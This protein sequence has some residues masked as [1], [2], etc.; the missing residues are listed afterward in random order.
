MP[1]YRCAVAEGATSLDQRAQIAKAITN[2]HCEITG[3]PP[4]FVHAFFNEVAAADLP[5]DKQALVFGSIR[6][7][8]TAEQQAQLVS[9][10]ARKIGA[11]LGCTAEGVLVATV[12]VPARWIME[13]GAI[14]PEP[15]EEAAWLA[16]HGS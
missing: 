7:G 8:R 14:L 15:G 13:G 3:A 9:D 1:L 4:T 5:E 10:M 11:V 2:I 6:A 16:E 12:D